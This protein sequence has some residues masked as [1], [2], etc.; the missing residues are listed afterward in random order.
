MN[1]KLF[2]KSS[3]ATQPEND[4][5]LNLIQNLTKTCHRFEIEV[6]NAKTY[7]LL[8]FQTMLKVINYRIPGRGPE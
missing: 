8:M 2:I 5:I 4:V 6:I 3:D 1:G 7:F